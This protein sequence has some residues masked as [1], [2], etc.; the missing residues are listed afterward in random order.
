MHFAL[1]DILK[2]YLRKIFKMKKSPISFRI[3]SELLNLLNKICEKNQRSK[4]NMFEKLIR[5]EAERLKIKA[6]ALP[7][8]K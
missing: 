6:D 4:T 3:D 7:S 8:A 5:D 2:L 1:L